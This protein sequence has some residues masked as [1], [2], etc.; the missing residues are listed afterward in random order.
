M[1]GYVRV[2]TNDLAR[3]A[4]FYD[5]LLGDMGAKRLIDTAGM[6][7]WGRDWEQSLL[8]V[9]TASGDAPA[10][11]GHGALVAL[12]QTSRKHVDRL[13]ARAITLGARDGGA[14][15]L[16]GTEGDQGYYAG[17]LHDPDG[18]ALCLYSLG[19]KE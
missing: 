10:T 17:Y 5:A 2:G 4:A 12:V 15:A 7:A 9:G 14:P 16:L 13:H 6:I 8:A 3:A 18:N 19:P 1:I 11:P